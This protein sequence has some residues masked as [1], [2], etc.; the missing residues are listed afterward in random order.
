MISKVAGEGTG[1]GVPPRLV[2]TNRNMDSDTRP[3]RTGQL[4]NFAKRH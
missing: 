4:K 2:S 3:Q 1:H